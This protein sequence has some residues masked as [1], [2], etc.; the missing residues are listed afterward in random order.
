MGIALLLPD[1]LLEHLVIQR[2][3]ENVQ[4]VFL[5]FEACGNDRKS[6]CRGRNDV[7]KIR[8]NV[9]AKLSFQRLHFRQRRLHDFNSA[10]KSRDCHVLHAGENDVYVPC[11]VSAF[12]AANQQRAVTDTILPKLKDSIREILDWH[13]AVT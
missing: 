7:N 10:K 2:A 1:P 13:G 6:L 11:L 4:I 8:G 9:C 3:F 12:R 5:H